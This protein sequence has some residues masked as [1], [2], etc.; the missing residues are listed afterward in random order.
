MLGFKIFLFKMFRYVKFRT[1]LIK[2]LWK[3]YCDICTDSAA[4]LLFHGIWAYQQIFSNIN[5][6][7]IGWKN[8][9][10]TSEALNMQPWFGLIFLCMIHLQN[11]FSIQ[12]FCVQGVSAVIEETIHHN[13][14]VKRWTHTLPLIFSLV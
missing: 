1:D 6:F 8:A 12:F 9:W 3:F 13:I 5:I 14:Q 7:M 2:S 10:Y 4:H 11:M